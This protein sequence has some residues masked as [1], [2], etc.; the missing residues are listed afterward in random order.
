MIILGGWRS[1]FCL[2]E[3]NDCC[4][5]FIGK[6]TDNMISPFSNDTELIHKGSGE[7]DELSCLKKGGQ[8]ERIFC[9]TDAW[10]WV[11][12]KKKFQSGSKTRCNVWGAYHV[13]LKGSVH[14]NEITFS[15]SFVNRNH[16]TMSVQLTGHQK[17]WLAAGQESESW[18]NQHVST[19]ANVTVYSLFRTGF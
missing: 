12:S 16:K 1:R 8:T 17:F 9:E 10:V 6:P 5:G 11:L 2:G 15:Q 14:Q 4:L 3:I 19:R 13:C 7:L 18:T